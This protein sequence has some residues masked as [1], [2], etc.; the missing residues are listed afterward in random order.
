MWNVIDL[1]EDKQREADGQFPP[2]ASWND[3]H[4]KLMM[5]GM[6]RSFVEQLIRNEWNS[7]TLQ[8]NVWTLP[9]HPLIV[10]IPGKMTRLL[11]VVLLND[12]WGIHFHFEKS[13]SLSDCVALMIGTCANGWFELELSLEVLIRWIIQWKRPNNF[14]C[15]NIERRTK[16]RLFC[17]ISGHCVCV[18]LDVRVRARALCRQFWKS[19]RLF[20]WNVVD[21]V[22]M[23]RYE[24]R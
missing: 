14:V 21:C 13:Q 7:L 17:L 6:N 3:L 22:S 24:N 1:F 19:I 16:L 5:F 9:C 23:W 18:R 2:V 20:H 4:F 11:R 15:A 8:W 10:V 12:F